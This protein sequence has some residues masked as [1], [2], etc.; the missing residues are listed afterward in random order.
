MFYALGNGLMQEQAIVF[1]TN[2][3][4]LMYL[5]NDDDGRRD[6]AFLAKAMNVVIAHE[7]R[8]ANT[9]ALWLKLIIIFYLAFVF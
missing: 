6:G 2:G 5:G 3:K 4:L 9:K 7:K 1:H 8:T